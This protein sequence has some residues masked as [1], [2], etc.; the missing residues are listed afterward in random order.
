MSAT[1]K[2]SLSLEEQ[3]W[4]VSLLKDR[5]WY[6]ALSHARGAEQA[7]YCPLF[8]DYGDWPL[9]IFAY[10]LYLVGACYLPWILF[11]SSSAITT[12]CTHHSHHWWSSSEQGYSRKVRLGG[13]GCAGEAHHHSLPHD[14]RSSLPSQSHGAVTSYLCTINSILI[15][16]YRSMGNSAVL[17]LVM[18]SF[19]SFGWLKLGYL[20]YNVPKFYIQCD[21]KQ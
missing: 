12:G 11:E 5:R 8:M 20:L 3:P 18:H 7:L 9:V 21:Y 4:E 13:G 14:Y 15:G 1:G 6:A 19:V 17:L 16:T 2:E 10:Q